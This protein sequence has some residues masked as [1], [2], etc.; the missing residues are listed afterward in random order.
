MAPSCKVRELVGT[1]MGGAGGKEH[2]V[3]TKTE[4]VVGGVHS[5][6]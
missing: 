1:W 2:M 5:P 6:Q 4:L 3:T